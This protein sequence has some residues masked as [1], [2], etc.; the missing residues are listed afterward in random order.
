MK[1]FSK[2]LEFSV[3]FIPGLGHPPQPMQNTTEA[4]EARLLY[5]S[6]TRA[7][8]VRSRFNIY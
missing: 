8:D 1:L 4:D 6:M 2:G 7:N 5:V 3:V